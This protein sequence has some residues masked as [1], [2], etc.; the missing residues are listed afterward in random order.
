MKT[1]PDVRTKAQ[2]KALKN[3]AMTK[4]PL[5]ESKYCHLDDY[6]FAANKLKYKFVPKGQ[7]IVRQGDYEA[8]VY[9]IIDGKAKVVMKGADEPGRYLDAK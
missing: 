9:F 4:M 1:I 2:L 6:I 3:F 7:Y 8:E 5:M